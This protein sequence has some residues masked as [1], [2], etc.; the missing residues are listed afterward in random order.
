MFLPQLLEEP[1]EKVSLLK[2]H[3]G[4]RSLVASKSEGTFPLPTA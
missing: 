1:G 2:I 3:L 4:I